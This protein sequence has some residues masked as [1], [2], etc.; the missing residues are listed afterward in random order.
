MYDNVITKKLVIKAK[1][2][3]M[4]T[5]D[6]LELNLTTQSCLNLKTV[7]ID[8]D[9][10]GRIVVDFMRGVFGQNTQ[11]KQCIKALEK[12]EKEKRKKKDKERVI[13]KQQ[14]ELIN[15]YFLQRWGVKV[16]LTAL[17]GCD[18]GLWTAPVQEMLRISGDQG[19]LLQPTKQEVAFGTDQDSLYAVVTLSGFNKG[20][21]NNLEDVEGQ[22]KIVYNITGEA[23]IPVGQCINGQVAEEFNILQRQSLEDSKSLGELEP[24]TLKLPVKFKR[25]P[26]AGKSLLNHI[27]DFCNKVKGFFLRPFRGSPPKATPIEAK[28]TKS[29]VNNIYEQMQKSSTSETSHTPRIVSSIFD[30]FRRRPPVIA[31]PSVKYKPQTILFDSPRSPSLTPTPIDKKNQLTTPSDGIIIKQ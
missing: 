3:Y 16:P 18:Q 1:G 2:L 12:L 21:P 17:P 15:Q 13:V 31:K 27:G 9:K 29:R 10:K 7:S 28:E 26:V 14:Y 11:A 19:Y 8:P 6:I 24:A 23:L 25:E 20:L 30:C 4:S 5:I 22:L